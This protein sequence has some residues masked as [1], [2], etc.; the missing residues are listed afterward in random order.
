[1]KKGFITHRNCIHAM[2][3]FCITWTMLSCSKD[4][5]APAP[6]TDPGYNSRIKFVLQDNFNFSVVNVCLM[7]AGLQDSLAAPGPFT[8]LAPNNNSWGN[9]GVG[10]NVTV[11]TFLFISSQR[12]RNMMRYHTLYGSFSFRGLPVGTDTAY[13]T[14]SGGHLYVKK[15]VNVKDTVVTVNGVKVESLDNPA[16][17]GMVQGLT[18]VLNPEIYPT[19][20]GFVHNEPNLTMFSAALQRSGLDTA[21]LSGN[22]V[23]TVLAPSNKAF[24]NSAGK[25]PGI[26]ISS[27][28]AIL[29]AAP[30]KLAAI[31]K[32]HMIKGRFYQGDLYRVTATAPG[33]SMIMLNNGKVAVNGNASAYNAISFLGRGN[34]GNA[35]RIYT[36]AE[37]NPGFDYASIT[38]GNGVLYETDAVLIP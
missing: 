9:L 8:F 30:D 19:I 38:C 29:H 33:K 21:L 3:L 27:I 11:N 34:Q 16:S 10:I 5:D 22:D 35:A 28:D 26:D 6:T 25:F 2:L 14:V 23:Y 17:N 7:Y 18:A 20:A 1:M 13:T 4:K 36:P 15:F 37:Y 31:L 12:M 24:I 32:Y